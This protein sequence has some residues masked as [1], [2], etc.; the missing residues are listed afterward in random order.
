M[1]QNAALKEVRGGRQ[2]LPY[3][4]IE[5]EYGLIFEEINTIANRIIA[6]LATY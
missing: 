1:L 3:V 6:I 4:F 2:Y 5:Q